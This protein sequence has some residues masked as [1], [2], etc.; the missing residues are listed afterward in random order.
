LSL[1]HSILNHQ[2][3]STSFVLSF[4]IN[5]EI[6]AWNRVLLINP[7]VSQQPTRKFITMF[8]KTRHWHRSWFRLM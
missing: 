6:A 3:S 7:I 4:C 2:I 5:H 1:I 8:T